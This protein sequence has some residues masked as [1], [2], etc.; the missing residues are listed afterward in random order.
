[1]FYVQIENVH[2][3]RWMEVVFFL[4]SLRIPTFHT[5]TNHWEVP[6]Q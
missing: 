3:N 1:M 6:I 2:K 5:S 4:F